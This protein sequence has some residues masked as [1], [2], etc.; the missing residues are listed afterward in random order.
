MEIDIFSPSLSDDVKLMTDRET[1]L[2]AYEIRDYLLDNV[3]KTGGHLA[4]NLGVVELTIAL[5]RVFSTPRDKLI[6]DV[7]HQ[8]YVHKILTGRAADLP[9]LRQ[10]GGMSGFPKRGESPHDCFDTGHSSNSISAA[11][12]MTAARDLAGDDYNVVAIIG[13][14]ALTGGMAYEALNTAGACERSLIVVLNDNGM[15]ISKSIGGIS[16]HLNRLRTSRGYLQFKKHLKSKV[17]S[18]PNVGESIYASMEH[19]RDLVKYS[20]VEGVFFEEMGFKYMGPIDGHDIEEMTEAL[21]LAKR[22]GGPVVVHVITKKG[23]GYRNAELDPGKF[24]GIGPFEKETGICSPACK[25]SYSDLFGKTL[26]TLAQED[27]RIAAVCAAM[28]DGT[29]LAAFARKFPER[30]FDVGIAEA[31]AVTFAAGMATR[32][33]RPVVAIYST[34]LQRAYD[35]IL[36]DVCM[37]NLPVIFAIDRAGNVGNDGETHHG[38]FDISYLSHMPNMTLLAPADGQEL[39]EMMRYALTCTGPVA[40]RYPRGAATQLHLPQ[41]KPFAGKSIVL[42]QGKD[43]EIFAVG[44]MVSVALAVS[45]RLAL[46]GCDIGVV[47][48]AQ[49][50]PPDTEAVF[51]ALQRTKRIVTLEDNV[52]KSG[53]GETANSIVLAAGGGQT[54]NIGWPQ[55]FI[56]HGNT[57]DLFKLYHL[58]EDGITER[59]REFLEG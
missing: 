38:I 32:G 56:E 23:K 8:S 52:L 11:A 25:L 28:E 14:G 13:D 15:S 12:G 41:R 48:V 18:I 2:L 42:K 31:H 39:V 55:A 7:G 16:H 1:E 36:I 50:S 29:G 6:W 51:G 40:I 54:L 37:Q 27:K 17:K 59:I 35:Q 49:V 47:N 45:E 34:F 4:S 58:D 5:H 22:A 21:Q 57:E 46:L 30:M 20:L 9:T 33:F 44:N 53:F 10:Q 24:H 3:S 19:L 26:C 43:A